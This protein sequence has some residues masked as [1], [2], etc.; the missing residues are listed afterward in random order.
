MEHSVC[1]IGHRK[2][3]KTPALRKQLEE[4]LTKLMANGTVNFL[5]GDHSAFDDLCYQLVTELKKDFPPVRRIHFRR[6]YEDAPPE[7]MKYLLPGYED[8]ICPKGVGSAGRAS[9]IKRNQAMIRESDVCVF[10]YDEGYLPPRRKYGKR[11]LTEYQPQSGTAAAF[12]YAV[13]QGKKII[14]CFPKN[15]SED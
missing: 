8:S 2:I 5:F 4:I 13:S 9:Y 3:A 1:F 15:D 11:Y 14:N 7:M 10:Y 12:A 6:D